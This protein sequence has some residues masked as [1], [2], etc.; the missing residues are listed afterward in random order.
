M[1]GTIFRGTD[2]KSSAKMNQQDYF[3]RPR[4]HGKERSQGHELWPWLC[5]TTAN[6]P[7]GL[8]VA[9]GGPRLQGK[10]TPQKQTP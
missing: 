9:G 1:T 3:Q 10:Y 2:T 6:T 8:G 5:H 4:A 7:L